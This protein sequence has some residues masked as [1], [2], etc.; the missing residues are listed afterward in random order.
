MTTTRLFFVSLTLLWSLLSACGDS[1]E[2]TH[3]HDAHEHTDG[4]VDDHHDDPDAAA[5]HHDDP[6]AA[7]HH[8]H[9]DA[10]HET[11][12]E[13]YCHLALENCT[14][15]DAL[16]AD[17]DECMTACAD[18][19]D[20]GSEGDTSGDTVQCRITH[21]QVSA[22]HDTLVCAHGAATGGDKCL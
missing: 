4:A 5:D 21:L 1:S 15:D 7:A 17:E 20:T 16:F 6:D 12:C 8:H 10:G 14:G 13:E 18:L 9:D 2:D 11:P 22:D 3:D 19:D